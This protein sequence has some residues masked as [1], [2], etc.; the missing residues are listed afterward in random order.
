MQPVISIVM[1]HIAMTCMIRILHG[2][3]SDPSS[4]ESKS[5]GITTIYRFGTALHVRRHGRYSRSLPAEGRVEISVSALLAEP[6]LD[7]MAHRAILLK[8]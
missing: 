1:V 2:L 4:A 5:I 7:K 3:S 6:P 8:R